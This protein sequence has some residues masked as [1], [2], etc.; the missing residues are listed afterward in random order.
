MGRSIFKKATFTSYLMKRFTY[1]RVCFKDFLKKINLSFM[2]PWLS[3]VVKVFGFGQRY[4]RFFFLNSCPVLV[5]I[6]YLSKDNIELN[7]IILYLCPFTTYMYCNIPA[8][9]HGS[10][11]SDINKNISLYI[12]RYSDTKVRLRSGTTTSCFTNVC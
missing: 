6:E 11:E 8:V 1:R 3:G 4:R 7:V 5:S 10:S 2:M 9:I 12:V